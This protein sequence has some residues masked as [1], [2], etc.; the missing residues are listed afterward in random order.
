MTNS[1][2]PI[3]IFTDGSYYPD[4][5]GEIFPK[6]VGTAKLRRTEALEPNE[7][8]QELADADVTVA[9]RGQFTREVF[10]GLPRMRGLVKWG[11]GIETI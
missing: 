10:Q 1:S 2:S 8:I 9:R 7:L 3:V 11:A 4:D 6:L 5:F